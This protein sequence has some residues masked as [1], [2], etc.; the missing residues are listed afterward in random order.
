MDTPTP[1]TT[2]AAEEGLGSA[3]A[4]SA[5]DFQQLFE[6]TPDPYLLVSVD[7]TVVAASMRWE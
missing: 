3:P 6:A 7:F 2:P 5:L 1:R 4:P